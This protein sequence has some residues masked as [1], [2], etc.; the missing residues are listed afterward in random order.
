[1][2][3]HGAKSEKQIS[4]GSIFWVV[5]SFLI[6]D[7][8]LSLLVHSISRQ[9]LLFLRYKLRIV[10]GNMKRSKGAR[11]KLLFLAAPVFPSEAIQ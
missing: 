11:L 7:R 4:R 6:L 10:L 8:S 3:V 9:D 2:L 5:R 1:M